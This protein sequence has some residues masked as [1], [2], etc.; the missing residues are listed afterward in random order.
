MTTE[1]VART[2]GS[3]ILRLPYADPVVRRA[4]D[5]VNSVTVYYI[6][7]KFVVT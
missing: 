3:V 6:R 7:C 5:D 2:N 4:F 1:Y